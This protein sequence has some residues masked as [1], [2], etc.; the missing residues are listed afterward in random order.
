M[1]CWLGAT[2]LSHFRGKR[3]TPADSVSQSQSEG[4]E[5]LVF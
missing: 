4:K 5:Y 3:V 2:M 1:L